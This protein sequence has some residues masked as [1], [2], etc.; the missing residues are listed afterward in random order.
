ML[1]YFLVAILQHLKLA[2]LEQEAKYQNLYIRFLSSPLL[3]LFFSISPFARHLL[4]FISMGKVLAIKSQRRLLGRFRCE[5]V[6]KSR[7][8]F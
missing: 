5:R 7:K 1:P 4:D 6:N 3:L 8:C 2:Y